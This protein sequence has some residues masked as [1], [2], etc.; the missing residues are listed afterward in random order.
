MDQNASVSKREMTISSVP[1]M[2]RFGERI[3]MWISLKVQKTK[4]VVKY[5]NPVEA[6]QRFTLKTLQECKIYHTVL[7]LKVVC[8][9]SI[10]AK[11]YSENMGNRV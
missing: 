11:S 8:L 5:F 7:I 9:I 2:F 1:E 3:E 6:K 4:A 10:K